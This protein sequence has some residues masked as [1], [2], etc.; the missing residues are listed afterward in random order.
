MG[1]HGGGFPRG[2]GMERPD[3]K[4]IL[5]E[6]AKET[7]GGYYEV[8]KK[9]TVG[10]IYASIEEELRNQYSIGY[11]SDAAPGSDNFRSIGVTVKKKNLV[12]QARNGYYPKESAQ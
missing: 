9:K 10:D 3:G 12:V 2:G 7:G 5:K 4:K 6:I 1:R 11:T 8:S